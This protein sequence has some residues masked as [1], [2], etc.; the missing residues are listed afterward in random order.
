MKKNYYVYKLTDKITG[1][2]YIG[3][4]GCDCEISEDKYMGSPKVWKPNNKNLLKE[5]LNLFGNRCDAIL[6]ERELILNNISNSLNMNFGIPHPNIAREN[7]V[8]AKDKNGKIISIS[9]KDPLF[10]VEYFG[11][12][13]GLVL[14]KD[15][16]NNVFLTDLSDPRYV[17]GELSHYNK[18][19]MLNKDHPNFNKI[20]VNNG[21][22][23]K[24]IT[25]DEISEGWTVGTLQKGKKTLSSHNN[26]LWVHNAKLKETRRIFEGDLKKY[27]NNGWSLGRIKLGVYK[28]S[29]KP[30]KIVLPDLKGYKWICNN[31]TKVNKRV[32][33]NEVSDFI[34]NGWSIGRL[35]LIPFNYD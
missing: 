32:L 11:V 17:S 5:V 22:Q 29:E 13:K 24:L 10:G 3:S 30:R 28:K 25:I 12:T 20:W 14:V 18:G 26:T 7:L 21:H 34:K 31:N 16:E 33:P 8:T 27:S 2:F 23:Q 4:R 6:H 15:N 19:L 9:T 35:N 1:E